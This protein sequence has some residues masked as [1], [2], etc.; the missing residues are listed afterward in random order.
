[1]TPRRWVELSKRLAAIERARKRATEE[2]EALNGMPSDDELESRT[3][4]EI[5]ALVKDLAFREPWPPGWPDLET[6]SCEE[7]HD[8][9]RELTVKEQRDR[10]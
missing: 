4:E 7:I 5:C 2:E 8:F 1:M 6:A 9:L 3:T 10:Y